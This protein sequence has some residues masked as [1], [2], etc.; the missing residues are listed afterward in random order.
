MI[1]LITNES[2][3]AYARTLGN[4]RGWKERMPA[5]PATPSTL[6]P[7]GNWQQD[8][9]NGVVRLRYQEAPGQPWHDIGQ[10]SANQAPA[11]RRN[12]ASPRAQSPVPSPQPPAAADAP[13]PLIL[14]T[15]SG[16][17]AWRLNAYGLAA[18]Q[19]IRALR[20]SLLHLVAKQSG[21]LIIDE[22]V[23]DTFAVAVPPARRTP[24][25]VTVPKHKAGR[26][27]TTVA[28]PDDDDELDTDRS[29][30]VDEAW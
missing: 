8:T 17:R 19:T 3:T 11:N 10:W 18:D 20:L 24:P 9:K 15:P 14:L 27:R 13:E 12:G 6:Q 5:K 1:D 16:D 28:Y 30:E 22:V 21:A 7:N 29:F 2:I 26:V 23:S 25:A 4:K